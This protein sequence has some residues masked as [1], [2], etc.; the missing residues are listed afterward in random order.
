MVLRSLDELDNVLSRY[1]SGNVKEKTEPR[2][3]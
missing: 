1:A 2:P 3:I